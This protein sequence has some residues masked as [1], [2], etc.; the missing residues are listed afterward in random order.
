MSAGIARRA[1]KLYL[2]NKQGTTFVADTLFDF[3]LLSLFLLIPCFFKSLR[4]N[5]PS[6]KDFIYSFKV[7]V[8]SKITT[9]ILRNRKQETAPISR[10]E[11]RA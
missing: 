7:F 9:K 8:H 10:E 3:V 1:E 5:L 11:F 4:Q 2:L 6:S